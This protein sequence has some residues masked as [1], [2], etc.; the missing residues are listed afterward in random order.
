MKIHSLENTG[1]ISV[2]GVDIISLNPNGTIQIGTQTVFT[3]AS[4]VQATATGGTITN[5]TIGNQIING[6]LIVT[7]SLTAQQ[8]IV[9]SSVTY[10]TTSFASGST[11][12][13]DTLDDIHGFTGSLSISGS[14]I[15]NGASYN[16]TTSGTSG[17]NGTAGSGGTSGSSGTD[18][19]GG[20]SGTNGTA[21]SGGTSGSSGTDG[22]GGTSGSSGTNGTGGTSGTNGTAGSGGTSGANGSSGDTGSSGSAG[23]SGIDGTSGTSGTN[24]TAG[25]GGTSGADGS[26]GATGSSGSAGT[27]GTSGTATTSTRVE[28]NFIATAGQTTFTV[29]GGYTVGLVDVFVNGVRFLPTEY[30][31]TNGTTVVFGSGLLV[32]DEVTIINYTSVI[33]ALPTSRNVQDFTATSGQTTF[34]V[35]NGYIVGL[36][37]VF[38]NGSKLT[39]SEFTATNGTTFVLT[40]ASTTGDQV[41]SINYTA[42]VNGVSGAGTTNELAYYTASSTLSSLTT[43]TY[44][45]L[46]ELSYVKG[47]TSSLQTQLNAKASSSSL[48]GYLPLSGGTLTGA[49]G[50]NNV[51]PTVPL[52]VTG[53]AKIGGNLTVT[54]NLTAQQFIVSS[55]VTYLTQSFASGSHKFGDSSDD[56]HNFTG[57]LIV[58]G[59]ANPFKVGSNLLFVSSSGNVGIGTTSPFSLFNIGTRPGSTNPSLGSI[60]TITNDG[61]TGIDLG[62]NVNANNV[63]GHINWVNYIG[64]G[65]YNTAR[66]DVYADGQGNSGALR[67]WTSNVSS[68]PTERMRITSAGNVGIGT[69]TPAVKLNTF[70]STDLSTIQIRAESDTSSVITYVG[71]SAS[72]IE[73]SRP[74]ITSG[75]LTIQTKVSA[76]SLASGGGAIV[77]SPNGTASDNTPVERMR[78][79]MDGKV[80]IGTTSPNDLLEIKTTSANQGNIRLYNTF[81]DG[82][83]SNGLV[84]FRNYDAATNTIGGYIYYTR[85]GGSTGDMTFGTGTNSAVS[86]R[87]RITSA[88]LVQITNAGSLSNSFQIYPSSAANTSGTTAV[89]QLNQSFAIGMDTIS[90]LPYASMGGDSAMN[91]ILFRT[92]SGGYAYR[93][94]FYANG[95]AYNSTGTWGN[96]SDIKLKQDIVDASSQWDDIKSLNF[97]KYRLKKDVQNELNST[98]GFIA[99]THFGLIAQDVE[100]TSPGLVEEVGDDDGGTTKMLKTSIMLMKSVK[101][102]QEAMV[103]IENLENEINILKLENN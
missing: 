38:V 92:Y 99:P 75:V 60:A 8:F 90:S 72:I 85:T 21:G 91:G 46:T 59:S 81:N 49:L 84:W 29:T 31:A 96:N 61:L 74:A 22:T 15:I 10:L 24:G 88:G 42:S 94:Y 16:T 40:I 54:G 56:N 25:S 26:S 69:S 11:K 79:L 5:Q 52:D 77:F 53:D 6:N 66:I 36:L 9:S 82:T 78:I 71:L 7:G 51:S 55:S 98:D 64:V 57:S 80:G 12:F 28:E 35:T 27:S 3:S 58:S 65:N 97:K 63:V 20:T 86:E 19:T 83:S 1:S 45:S 18:G 47:V 89:I 87:M 13:G 23:T 73:Y 76:A 17:T 44:P 93:F 48:S 14:L 37:D 67:F 41:Q 101:A 100:Q 102:L 39:S 50:V 30:T 4:Y 34:T 70:L 33:V 68:T 103:R 2:D 43:A 95:T 32:N 62:G